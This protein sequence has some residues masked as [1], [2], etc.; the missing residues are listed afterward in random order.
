MTDYWLLKTEPSEFGIDDLERR[1]KHTEPWTGVR[2]YQARNFLRAMCRGDQAFLYHSS[3]ARPGIAAI[4][5]IA[6]A[7]YPD[8]GAFDPGSPYYDAK[9]D[10]AQPRWFCVDVKLERRLRREI[11]L[12]ELKG[13]PALAGFRLL[14]PG[15]RLSVLPVS[16]AH[17][18][19]I[20]TMENR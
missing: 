9:S 18:Q 16:A 20:L 2:N 5:R 14:A 6:R 8:P 7:A 17:W 1:P 19:H 12:A 3:C 11:P 10:P 13:E 4:V 15:N